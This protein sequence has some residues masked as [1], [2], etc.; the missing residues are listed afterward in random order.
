[1]FELCEI[2]DTVKILPHL[3]DN[4]LE[5]VEI[6]LS[7][8]YANFVIRNVG[9]VISVYSIDKIHNGYVM[10]GAGSCYSKVSGVRRV[11]LSYKTSL[12]VTNRLDVNL[13]YLNHSQEKFYWV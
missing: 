12:I 11:S 7:K 9:L 10:T 3:F 2:E 8:K 13:L 4:E 5:A 6:E 1:M